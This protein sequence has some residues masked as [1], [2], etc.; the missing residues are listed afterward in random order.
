M[1]TVRFSEHTALS[2][3]VVLTAARDFSERR[4]QMWPD[5]HVSHLQV[6]EV[7]E[8]TGS[9]HANTLMSWTTGGMVGPW[10]VE[11]HPL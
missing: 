2:P 10:A 6:H 9:R 4:A 3:D 8:P 7:G 1:P 11:A 5:V